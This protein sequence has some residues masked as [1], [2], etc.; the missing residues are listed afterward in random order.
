MEALRF[1]LHENEPR[2]LADA[3]ARNAQMLQDME[4]SRMSAEDM[5]T[6]R[7]THFMSFLAQERAENDEWGDD[8]NHTLRFLRN[9]VADLEEAAMVASGTFV[10]ERTRIRTT[11]DDAEGS[12]P[13]IMTRLELHEML[14][15]VQLWRIHDAVDAAVRLLEP[16]EDDE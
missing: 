7:D 15:G 10:Q 9:R 5:Q 1:V 11:L 14:L 3:K 4:R 16:E 2:E 8:A 6:R 12:D 13:E